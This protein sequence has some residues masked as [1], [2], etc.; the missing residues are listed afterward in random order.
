MPS[1][2]TAVERLLQCNQ[3]RISNPSLYGQD[4][5]Y[6]PVGQTQIE[7]RAEVHSGR[8]GFKTYDRNTEGNFNDYITLQNV[9]LDVEPKKQDGVVVNGKKYTVEEFV[10]FGNEETAQYTILC[11]YSVSQGGYSHRRNS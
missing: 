3:W 10:R 8:F 2:K 11:R 1:P 4:I 5:V 7:I 6:Q 9:F